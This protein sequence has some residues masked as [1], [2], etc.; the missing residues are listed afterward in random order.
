M[1][2]QLKKSN[3]PPLGCEVEGDSKLPQDASG[4]D[5]STGTGGRKGV[6]KPSPE[7]RRQDGK[8]G[9]KKVDS[10]SPSRKAG[11]PAPPVSNGRAPSA[12]PVPN[13][14]NTLPVAP[15]SAPA[16]V[17]A[18][19]PAACNS[20]VK[21]VIADQKHASDG[22]SDDGPALD[23]EQQR[24][25]DLAIK[26][27]RHENESKKRLEQAMRGQHPSRV[28]KKHDIM[29]AEYAR[30]A[31]QTRAYTDAARQKEK[32]DAQDARDAV[33]LSGGVPE[34][35]KEEPV[36][37]Q[38]GSRI[39]LGL[40]FEYYLG[41]LTTSLGWRWRYF[42]LS[43][44][45]VCI[46]T[47]LFSVSLPVD[48]MSFSTDLVAL[49]V[50][51][52][53]IRLRKATTI[54]PVTLEN[55]GHAKTGRSVHVRVV[56]HQVYD[57]GFDVRPEMWK[58]ATPHPYDDSGLIT[59]E[60]QYVQY[61]E[62]KNKTVATHRR[63]IS[64]P[65]FWQLVATCQN[66]KMSETTQTDRIISTAKSITG[67]NLAIS[68]VE[69][70]LNSQMVAKLYLDYMKYRAAVDFPIA[71]GSGQ[72]NTDIE[73]EKYKCQRLYCL[74]KNPTSNLE[75]VLW[76][77]SGGLSLLL[78]AVMSAEPHTQEAILITC[79]TL[80]AAFLSAFHVI[81]HRITQLCAL[82]FQHL[83]IGGLLLILLL[84][85]RLI[86][87]MSRSGS[88]RLIIMVLV[89]V[90]CVYLMINC[91][92]L[93]VLTVRTTQSSSFLPSQ[94]HTHPT[95]TSGRYMR[96]LMNSNSEWDPSSM[97]WRR[98]YINTQLSLSRCHSTTERDI[99]YIGCSPGTH[100]T[101]TLPQIIRLSN[102]TSHLISWKQLNLSSIVHFQ[103]STLMQNGLA[104]Y[105]AELL[106]VSTY[107][108][109]RGVEL[110]YLL[111]ECQERCARALAMDSRTC[112]SSN[113][114]KNYC[115]YEPDAVLLRVTMP[116]DQLEEIE[117]YSTVKF[118]AAHVTD[119]LP[120]EILN[121]LA[122]K[123]NHHLGGVHEY[124]MR[125][126]AQRPQN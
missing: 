15:E 102:R 78:W 112:W 55:F 60:I 10:Q 45:I 39:L 1:T 88:L 57:P 46:V 115:V 14:V 95:S 84:L 77:I 66:L 19:A 89:S 42:S 52:I 43:Y 92:S 51:Y 116:S 122:N 80:L 74:G 98:T 23:F 93:E 99:Y 20:V 24:A 41:P 38:V 29:R 34:K 91:Q 9:G 97:L 120:S 63:E 113:S 90:S 5:S 6:G 117:R 64:L 50:V 58:S 69:V 105:T 47:A 56:G 26:R 13:G 54:A 81:L 33:V 110:E 114:S 25:V 67:V 21:G 126:A 59:V 36:P 96:G 111:G 100:T 107:A 2:V 87:W 94:N 121:K 68:S 85:T 79:Q 82:S 75:S 28:H 4:G 61:H 72:C 49:V 40:N 35:K 70:Q 53:A 83:L 109:Q 37:K 16:V 32:E 30:L 48:I 125:S 11:V 118:G 44:L 62:F 106:N 65:Y 86:R 71:Q 108:S 101:C 123:A 22:K 31:D 103:N 27:L 119:A 76:L 104:N 18:E 7:G 8:Y 3:E 124:G 17:G 12:P 73:L